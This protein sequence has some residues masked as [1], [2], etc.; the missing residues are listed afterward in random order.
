MP[1]LV[2]YAEDAINS[3]QGAIFTQQSKFSIPY[4]YDLIHS[5]REVVIKIN[6]TKTGKANPAW[7]QKYY[8]EFTEALQESTTSVKFEC[9]AS[10]IMDD[11]TD[12]FFYI[13]TTDGACNFRKNQNRADLAMYQAHRVT[14]VSTGGKIKTIWSDGFLEVVGNPL[15]KDILIDGIFANPTLLPD[16]N[17]EFSEYPLD[18]DSWN[19][20]KQLLFPSTIAR[21]AQ[22]PTNAKQTM[23][24]L[25]TSITK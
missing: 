1:T 2:K 14:K 5:F 19:Q 3:E 15:Q 11:Q 17:I 18:G 23:V 8:P 22:S 10:V 16:Y 12:G 9:P 4:I 13:G 25:P 7:F 21:Q 24:D 20:I 6:Y